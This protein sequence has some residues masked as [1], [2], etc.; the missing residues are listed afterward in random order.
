MA[1]RRGRGEG[2]IYEPPDGRWRAELNLGYRS[3][4]RGRAVRYASTQAAAR[5]SLTALVRDRDRGLPVVTERQTV[6]QFLDA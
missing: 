4:R 6:G 5:R 2:T 1:K 3:G